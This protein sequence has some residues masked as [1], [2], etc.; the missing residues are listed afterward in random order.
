MPTNPSRF[1]G[2]ASK[3]YEALS[4]QLGK[5]NRVKLKANGG[6][7]PNHNRPVAKGNTFIVRDEDGTIRVRFHYT[8]IVTVSPNGTITLDS[9]GFHTYTTKAR[10]NEVARLGQDGYDAVFTVHQKDYEWFVNGDIPFEDG[11][12]LEA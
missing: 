7:W 4:D 12:T 9:G 2:S 8:N 1:I 3:L 10:M 11:M 5:A 6:R